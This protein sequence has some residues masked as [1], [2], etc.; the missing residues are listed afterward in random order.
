MVAV[1]A[2]GIVARGS[3]NTG[4]PVARFFTGLICKVAA[5]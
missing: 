2:L 3:T 4:F 5:A 1:D